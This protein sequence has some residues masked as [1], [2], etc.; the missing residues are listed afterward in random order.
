MSIAIAE[1][2][3]RARR[4]GER[5]G[6][7]G[8][9]EPLGILEAERLGWSVAAYEAYV[10]VYD[11]HRMHWSRWAVDECS[12]EDLAVLYGILGVTPD[13]ADRVALA[14]LCRCGASRRQVARLLAGY[15]DSN[16]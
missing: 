4:D 3:F 14:D 9:W 16:N 6:L 8:R 5:D 12:V 1:V 2:V 13:P 7:L 10:A 15:K 11:R